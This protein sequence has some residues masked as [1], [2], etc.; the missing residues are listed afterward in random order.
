MEKY[1]HAYTFAFSLVN[2][3]PE[4]EATPHEIRTAI[5]MALA[6]MT[7][8]EIWENCGAPFDTFKEE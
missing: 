8:S 4:G 2:E 5:L 7:D 1:N 6:K 3:S